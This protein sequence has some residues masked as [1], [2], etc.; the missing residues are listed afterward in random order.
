[1]ARK[2]IPVILFA[3]LMV[4]SL[5]VR[6]QKAATGNVVADTKTLY[7]ILY[8]QVGISATDG[9]TGK[10]ILSYYFGVPVTDNPTFVH[11]AQ[12]SNNTFLQNEGNAIARLFIANADLTALASPSAAGSTPSIL[13]ATNILEGATQFLISRGEQELSMAFFTRFQKAMLQYP[14]FGVL[15]PKTSALLNNIN[16]SNLLTLLQQLRD[17]FMKDLLNM[18]KD[19]LSFRT[20][21]YTGTDAVIKARIDAIRAVLNNGQTGII[22][23]TSLNLVQGLIN[24]NDITAALNSAI[25]DPT[26]CAA[27][28]KL[29]S[30]L[31][32]ANFFIQI[33]KSNS[34]NDGVFVNAA[35]LQSLFSNKDE[36]NLFFGLA[37]QQFSG[38]SCYQ[39]FA[40]TVNINGVDHHL[41]LLQILTAIQTGANVFYNSLSDLQ[42]INAS[43]LGIKANVQKGTGVDASN[44][45]SLVTGVIDLLNNLTN[46]ASTILQ[47]DISADASM[48]ALKKN[49]NVA[50]DLCT[51]IQQKNYTGIFND[52]IQF[53]N[54][55][56]IFANSTVQ[57]DLVTYLSF[58]ANLASATSPDQVQNVLETVALPPGSYSIKQKSCVNISL[59][60]YIGYGWDIGQGHGIY[61]PIGPAISFGL[62][63]KHGG[64]FTIFIPLIDLGGIASYSVLNDTTVSSLK[65]NITFQSVI[66]PGIQGFIE[67]P[68]TPLAIG[69]GWRMTPSLFYNGSGGLVPVKSSSVFSIAILVDIPIFT[70]FNQPYK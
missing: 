47:D 36:L 23:V 14:E 57:Q 28:D 22:I 38:N 11:L 31:K 53:I 2:F 63:K 59:N 29:S 13:N 21:N 12:A 43:F 34:G 19:I 44:F 46:T 4:I 1:M 64:A 32:L 69:A 33:L 39:N 27:G 48:A 10:N 5:H 67:F 8:G 18:P 7:N 61:A 58:A 42:K 15:F 54:D 66:A 60:G 37:F 40:I 55:N 25:T 50:S 51:D 30:Y 24:G 9:Q 70:I 49:L 3:A 56:K 41:T 65:Q 20:F 45:G 6:C 35:D 26:V 52:V 68:K 62:G 16:N 17:A